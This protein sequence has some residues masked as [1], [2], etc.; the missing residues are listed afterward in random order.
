MFPIPTNTRVHGIAAG[1]DGSLW[2]TESNAN[3]IG[4][5]TTGPC[6]SDTTTLCLSGSR[7]GVQADW[8]IPSQGLSGH[9][10]A[11]R[12]TGDAGY[13]WF[14]GPANVEVVVKV[15]NGCGSVEGHYWVYAGGLT[16]VV[17]TLTVTDMQTGQTKTYT[18]P[19]GS[20]FQPILDNSAFA[21]CP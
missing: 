6:T 10:T 18:N 3:N 8:Q 19:S 9:G 2:F 12:M 21:S 13:F 16:D 14:F 4:R 1:P 7:F 15:L 17:V 5:I 11:V 20:L